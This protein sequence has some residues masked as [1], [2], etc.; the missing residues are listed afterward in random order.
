MRQLLRS[1]KWHNESNL[2]AV[3][4]A[5]VG[6]DCKRDRLE[7]YLLWLHESRLVAASDDIRHS[8]IGAN[9]KIKTDLIIGLFGQ[10]D[11][12]RQTLTR[13]WQRVNR[14]RVETDW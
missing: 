11:A 4:E 3:S 12:S 9:V 8:L 7:A 6:G 2:I 13:P 14:K 1:V 10:H 5:D